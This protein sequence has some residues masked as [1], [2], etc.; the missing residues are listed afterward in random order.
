MAYQ[1]NLFE[2]FSRR[3]FLGI[4]LGACAFLFMGG[5]GSLLALRGRASKIERLRC[6]TSH[7][8]RTLARLAE[9]LFPR[10]GAFVFGAEDVDLTRMFDQ[11]L[12]DEPQFNQNDLKK[13]LLLL[14]FGPILFEKRFKT[15]SHLSSTERLD[16]FVSWAN[17]SMLT[18]RKIATALRK[19]LSMVFYDRPEVWPH[20]GYDGPII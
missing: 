18:R 11:F 9:A 8:Y 1:N 16:H 7:E 15:F 19:F 4:T 10:D 6:L 17:S 3:R 5:T 13:A 14:E 2:L 12:A 20:I